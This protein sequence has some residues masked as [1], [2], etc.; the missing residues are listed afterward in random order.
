MGPVSS[1]V[2]TRRV[3]IQDYEGTAEDDVLET[4]FEMTD[5]SLVLT[6]LARSWSNPFHQM[7]TWSWL[8]ML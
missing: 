3:R 6:F 4:V 8:L 2:G 5:D 7:G 1:A